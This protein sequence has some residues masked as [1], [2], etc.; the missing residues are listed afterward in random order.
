LSFVGIA[1]VITSKTGLCL[2]AQRTIL[3]N[4]LLGALSHVEEAEEKGDPRRECAE[5]EGS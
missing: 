1:L 4:L 2:S 3:G 5:A